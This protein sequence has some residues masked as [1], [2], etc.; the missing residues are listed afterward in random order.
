VI[1]FFN[2]TS[3][4]NLTPIFNQYLKYTSLPTL[5]IKKKG[6]QI[7]YRWKTEE[8]NFEMPIDVVY[9][10][11]K[12]RLLASNQW[13]VSHFK[14]NSLEELTVLKDHFYIKVK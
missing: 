2:T 14:V 7:V 9:K 3:G 11:K 1:A 4:M 12:R 10:N 13:K 8:P 6:T 5:E